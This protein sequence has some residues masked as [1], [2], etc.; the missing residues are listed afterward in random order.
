[1][2]KQLGKYVLAYYPEGGC[3]YSCVKEDVKGPLISFRN[4]KYYKGQVIYSCDKYSH[5]RP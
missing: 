3:I 1:M 2:N 4:R 5:T